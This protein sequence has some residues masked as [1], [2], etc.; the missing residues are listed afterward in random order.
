M[1]TD[2]DWR[3]ERAMDEAFDA[4]R[5]R[6]ADEADERDRLGFAEGDK[7]TVGTG[8]TV[9]TVDSFTDYRD[10][11]HAHLEATTGY[12]KNTVHVD[13]LRAVTP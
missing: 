4:H 13:R 7:V 3:E 12:A 1:T 11:L 5:E 10:G 6:L 9:W 2:L 8:K